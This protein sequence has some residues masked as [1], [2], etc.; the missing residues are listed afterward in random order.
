MEILKQAEAIINKAAELR[1]AQVK[2]YKNSSM[3]AAA[4]LASLGIIT[5]LGKELDRLIEEWRQKDVQQKN[6]FD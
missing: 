3:N 1:A 2:Y 6:I 5:K 4:R